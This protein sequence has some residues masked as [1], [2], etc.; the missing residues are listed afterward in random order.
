VKVWDAAGGSELFT[1]EGHTSGVWSVAWSPDGMRLATAS[2]DGTVKMWAAA[3]GPELLT[4]KGHAG[5]VHSASWS[6]DGRRLSTGSADGTVKVWDA[7][8]AEAVEEW[9]HQGRAVQELLARNAFRGPHAQGFIQ[10]WLLLLPLSLASGEAGAEAMDRQ[11]LPGESQL[12]PRLGDRVLFGGRELVWQE[13]RSP[14]AAVSFNEVLGRVTDRSVAYAVC[15]LESDQARDGLWLQ[16]GGDDQTAVY[17]N[18]RQVYQ[19]RLGHPLWA[20]DTVG[21]LA[22]QQG[23]NVLLIKVVNGGGLWEVCA[24]LVD[25]AGLPAQG[26]RVKLMP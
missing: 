9:A 13:H 3:G 5:E 10:T 21:P 26:I 7:A 16:V 23:T 20:L 24:R 6:P 1:L 19:C 4:L 12:R 15:Y 11:Q 25:D 14:E 2:A 17:L 22:L 18:G 8:T